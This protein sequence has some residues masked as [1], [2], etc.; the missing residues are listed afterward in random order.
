MLRAW[1][2]LALFAVVAAAAA[3]LVSRL[4][5][6]VYRGEAVVRIVQGEQNPGGRTAD[7]LEVLTSTYA[8]LARSDRVFRAAARTLGRSVTPSRLKAASEVDSNEV[9]VLT[10][11]S[12]SRRP[13]Q[14]AAWATAYARG[15]AILVRR[16][17]EE[18]RRAAVGRLSAR[19]RVVRARL[20]QINAGSGEATALVNEIQQLAA[21]SADLNARQPDIA[22]IIQEARVPGSPASPKPLRNAIIALFIAAILGA[23]AV[24]LRSAV[25]TRYE[26]AEAL[27]QDLELPVLGELPRAGAE[28]PAT[29]DAFRALRTNLDFALNRRG[30][31][32]GVS[33]LG[34]GAS[35]SGGRGGVRGR[36]ERLLERRAAQQAD[37]AAPRAPVPV[38]LVTS[39]EPGAGK[40]YVTLGLARALTAAGERTILVDG[41]LRQPAVHD[42]LGMSLDPGVTH[43]VDGTTSAVPAR[44]VE[45]SSGD[46]RGGSLHVVTAGRRAEDSAE[47]LSTDAIGR[48]IDEVSST[49]DAV[50]VDS[51]PAL[52]ITDAAVLSRHADGVILVIDHKQTNRRRARRAK[53]ALRAV[54]AP[55]VGVVLNRVPPSESAYYQYGYQEPKAEKEPA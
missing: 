31:A 35:G 52:G 3:Y 44:P 1:R 21:R 5:D 32:A 29:R 45:A 28:E 7:D 6:D 48:L 38:L 11:T 15:F 43:L 37:P 41:D 12:E 51:A 19:L 36:A 23:A 39:P 40:T 47:L 8:E 13:R 33:G 10:L 49:Y 54:G 30:G 4:Q 2:W 20:D 14:A 16:D 24:Y 42:R 27:S 53:T 18:Q 17:G 25:S 55:V 26:S 9:G 34:D 50:V 22:R 46:R